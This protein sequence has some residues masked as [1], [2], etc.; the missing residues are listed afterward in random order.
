MEGGLSR[1][2]SKI[3]TVLE[4]LIPVYDRGNHF[5]SFGRDV[6]YRKESING[7]IFP[8]DLVLDAGCGPGNMSEIALDFANGIRGLIFL[9]A[10]K[11]MLTVAKNR[12]MSVKPSAVVGLFESLPFRNGTFDVVMLGFSIR[13]AKNTGRAVSEF[14]RVLKSNGGRLIIVDLGKPDNILA[15][16]IIGGYWKFFVLL[17][18]YLAISRLGLL[19]SALHITYWRLLRNS[20]FRSLL[21]SYF[22]KVNFKTKM[23]GMVV[24][25]Y[26][27]QK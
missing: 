22:S 25:I 2:W 12:L 27:E 3:V 8:S 14:H 15:R 4:K 16:C 10:S 7:H 11:S 20:E 19:Y 24:I 6:A 9:D 26:A 17:L 5:I 13:D 21:Q 18:A 23:A 1:D